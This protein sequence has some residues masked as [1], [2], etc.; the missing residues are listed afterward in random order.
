MLFVL[1]NLNFV[2]YRCSSTS[3]VEINVQTG[4]NPSS[5]FKTGMNSSK[6]LYESFKKSNTEYKEADMDQESEFE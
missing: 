1:L 5:T 4:D 2:L 6:K 3:L